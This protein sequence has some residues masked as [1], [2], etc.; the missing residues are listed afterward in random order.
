MFSQRV[1]HTQQQQCQQQQQQQRQQFLPETK[2]KKETIVFV[3][4]FDVDVRYLRS[5]VMHPFE[6]PKN[7][8]EIYWICSKHYHWITEIKK[9]KHNEN[10]MDKMEKGQSI[11][12]VDFVT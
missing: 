8:W 10:E 6:Y 5:I 4:V 9:K 12:V 1:A 11:S 2:T 7:E 3:F